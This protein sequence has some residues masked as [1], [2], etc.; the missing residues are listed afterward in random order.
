MLLEMVGAAA[1]VLAV[2]FEQ[3]MRDHHHVPRRRG[4]LPIVFHSCTDDL[5]LRCFLKIWVIDREIV[6]LEMLGLIKAVLIV[7]LLMH[8]SKL[9]AALAG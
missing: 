9:G 6:R 8:L 5:P 1:L 7:P 2:R 3:G 4:R